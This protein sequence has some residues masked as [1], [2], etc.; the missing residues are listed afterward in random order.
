MIGPHTSFGVARKGTTVSHT[1][2]A[3]GAAR[4]AASSDKLELAARVGYAVSGLLHLLIGWIALQTAF[5]GG[6]ESADQSGALSQIAEQPF[7]R[8]LLWIGVAG[9]LGLGL[10]Y[11]SQTFWTSQKTGERVKAAAK[12]L[13]Y[14]ALAWTTFTFAQG[15]GTDSSEQSTDMTAKILELPGGQVIVSVIGL[16]VLGVGGYHVYKGWA[17]KFLEDLSGGTGGT[18]GRA[19]V[20]LGMFGYVAKGVALAVVGVLFVVA[21]I[22]SDPSEATGLDGALNTLR[23]QPFGV[24][25][26]VV[27]ALGFAAYGVYSFARARYGHLRA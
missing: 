12:G 2:Q 16:V 5:G 6:G 13:V 4:Q 8:V 15:S 27:I 19:V 18:V 21:A 20:R 9:F 1:S 25:L 10:L 24:F 3:A 26:L 14:L 7:G 23:E 17:K 11:L 22:Q